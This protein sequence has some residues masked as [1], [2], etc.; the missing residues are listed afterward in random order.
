MSQKQVKRARQ[1]AKKYQYEI[2]RE[3]IR[4]LFELPFFQRL[5]T[6]WMIL[7]GRK[8]EAKKWVDR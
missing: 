2:M 4:G 7:K 5:A 1:L 8:K 3:S 6:A